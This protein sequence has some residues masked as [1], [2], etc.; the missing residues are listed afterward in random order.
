MMS[1]IRFLDRLRDRGFIDQWGFMAFAVIG[2][3][4]IPLVKYLGVNPIIVALSAVA[5]MS[6][7]ALLISRMGTGRVRA[8]Q[9]GDNCYYLGLIYTLASL[10][11][12]IFT[13]DPNNTAATIVSGFGI[14]L[15]TTVVGLILR[16][17]FNQGRPDLENVEEQARL[18]LT[19]AS[20]RLKAE[21]NGVVVQMND[22][23][24]QLQQSM[25][26]MHEAATSNM[27]AF[28]KT[29]IEGLKDLV[30]TANQSI[31]TESDDFSSRSKQFSNSF[32]SLV[33]KLEKHGESLEKLSAAHNSLG[34]AAVAA[35]DVAESALTSTIALQRSADSA[36]VAA[37]SA[38]NASEAATRASER[39]ADAVSGFEK[40][41][42]SIREE[43]DRQ[44]SEL[45]TGPARSVENAISKLTDAGEVLGRQVEKISELHDQV[46]A[47]LTR[48]TQS[49]LELSQRHNEGL[50]T[51]LDRSREL[52]TKVHSALADMTEK[53]ANVAEGRA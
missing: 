24:R 38:G 33:T 1:K 34:S 36:T 52:V 12:A 28:T 45:K 31:R 15:A 19:E 27:E 22:F 26:E 2:F 8:D 42:S 35:K 47:R 51:E 50:Q 16:V 9:A 41:L 20:T 53:L 23:S 39:L 48:E 29:S 17:F 7:Y 46:H 6:A 43:T 44:L 10:S 18:E 21:L 13:F 11:Y 5:T 49:S 37:T 4:V 40:S 14:A 32:N 25:Q 3:L 30:E